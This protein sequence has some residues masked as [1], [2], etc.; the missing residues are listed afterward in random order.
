MFI[1]VLAPTE[2]QHIATGV[3]P[4]LAILPQINPERVTHSLR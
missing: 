4:W 1:A 2:R 3:N